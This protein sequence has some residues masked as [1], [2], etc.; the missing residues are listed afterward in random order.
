MFFGLF[1]NY[2]STIEP[3]SKRRKGLP[4]IVVKKTTNRVFELVKKFL[5]K[6]NYYDVNANQEYNDI[7]GE[8]GGYEISIQISPNGSETLVSISVFGEKKRGKTRKYLKKLY[9]R[10]EK[11]LNE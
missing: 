6:E 11:L 2:S 7:Y 5:E 9:F 10:L 8:K 1:E 3:S 4:C